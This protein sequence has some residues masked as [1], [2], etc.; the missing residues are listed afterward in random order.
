[1]DNSTDE[2]LTI[3]TAISELSGDCCSSSDFAGTLSIAWNLDYGK[4]N[5]CISIITVFHCHKNNMRNRM[6]EMLRCTVTSVLIL[7]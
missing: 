3:S 4:Y 6:G 5:I 7:C 1:M 2:E